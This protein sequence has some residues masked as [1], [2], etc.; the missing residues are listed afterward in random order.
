MQRN[1]VFTWFVDVVAAGVVARHARAK[2]V[3]RR[4]SLIFNRNA[5][6]GNGEDA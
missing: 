6:D 4:F 2:T 5:P 1:L 3:V